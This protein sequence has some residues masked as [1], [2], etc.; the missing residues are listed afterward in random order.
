MKQMRPWEENIRRVVPYV[1]GEQPDCS[2]VIKLNTNECPYPPAP[3]VLEAARAFDAET[4]RLYPKFP[5]QTALVEELAVFYGVEKEQIF[6]GVGSDDVLANIFMTFFNSGKPVFFPAVTYSFYSVWADLFRIPYVRQPLDENFHIRPEDYKKEN[7]GVVF[8]NPNAP[9]SL[10][11]SLD[12]VRA[13]L[14]VNRDVIVVV[15][16]AYI[17]FG[18]VSALSLLPEYDNL[19]VTQTFSKS[20]SLA[21]ARIGFAIASREL[22]RA[23]SDVKYSYNSYTINSPALAMGVEAVR[24]KSYFEEV[25][26][27]I[28]RTRELAKIRLA[29]LGF[30]FPDSKANF[31]FAA[32]KSVPAREIFERL[33]KKNIYVRYF[34]QPGIDNYLRITIGTDGQMEAL[35]DALKEIT[36]YM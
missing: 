16:E 3:G 11:E 31:I 19:I 28:I 21:G 26:Q 18:G 17:D 30:T 35:Y 13:I 4:L 27:K 8:P 29:E 36:G 7:G 23:L 32:H 33:K 6:V 14:D 9:T 10:Y 1:P 25:L 34:D 2:D 24:D 12:T 22:I 15:D 20:R 5:E